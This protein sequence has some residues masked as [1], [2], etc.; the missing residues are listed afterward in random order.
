MSNQV[1]AKPRYDNLD[2]LK[3][4]SIFVVVT[5]H[6]SV[7]NYDFLAGG[8]ITNVIQYAVRNRSEERR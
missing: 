6:G 8:E 3:A 1:A 4:I 7:W 5:L 2:L